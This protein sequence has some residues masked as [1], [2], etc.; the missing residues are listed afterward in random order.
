[1]LA[2]DFFI[3]IAE[4]NATGTFLTRSPG[5]ACSIAGLFFVAELPVYTVIFSSWSGNFHFML[6]NFS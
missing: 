5:A 3:A 4:V 6:F 2:V 1:M